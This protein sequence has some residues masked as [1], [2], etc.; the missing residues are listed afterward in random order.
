[1]RWISL[2]FLYFSGLTSLWSPA[3]GADE[4]SA[5]RRTAVVRAVELAQPSV[6]SIH[7]TYRQQVV[8]RYRDPY[9]ISVSLPDNRSYEAKYIDTYPSYDLAI[10][11]VEAPDLPVAH[12]GNSDDIL[13]GEWAVAIGN[14][15]DLGPTVSVGVVSAVKRDFSQ[16]QGSYYYRDMIQTDAP[17]NP[18]NSGGPWSMP[19]AR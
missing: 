19:W 10:L 18:G 12:L 5:S 7:A 17:I 4:I 15:F 3:F 6:V 11:R 16:P 8:Y 2:F 14:P 1:M 13:V 9:K